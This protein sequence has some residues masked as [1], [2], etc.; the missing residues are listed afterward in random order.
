MAGQTY[1]STKEIAAAEQDLL[2]AMKNCDIQ[3]LDELLHDDLLFN[4]PTGHTITKTMDLET[5]SSG[6][7][8]IQEISPSNQ[9]INLIGDNAIVSI[10]V[11]MKGVYMNKSLDGKYRLIRVWKLLHNKW[12]VIAGSSIKV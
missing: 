8:K 7:M 9:Q 6:N 4:I 3:K 1:K 5:Y 10:S 2:N 11:E 12:K